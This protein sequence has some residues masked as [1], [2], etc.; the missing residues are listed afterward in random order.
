VVIHI[1]KEHFFKICYA[2]GKGSNMKA[3]LATMWT[4]LFYAN[5]LNIRKVHVFGDSKVAIDWKNNKIKFRWLNCSLSLTT[6]DPP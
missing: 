6:L 4:L 1:S 5:L 2:P 3:E